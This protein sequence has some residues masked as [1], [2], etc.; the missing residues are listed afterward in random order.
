MRKLDPAEFANRSVRVGDCLLWVG[1]R[2]G[3]YGLWGR[4]KYAHHEAYERAYGP[5]P[6]FVLH[7]CDTPLC[8]EPTHLWSGTQADNL[9]DMA[10]KGRRRNQWS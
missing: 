2:A 6:A 5:A 7:T 1:P 3:R 4:R 9:A 10:R 8:V